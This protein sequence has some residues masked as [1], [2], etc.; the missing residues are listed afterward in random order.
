MLYLTRSTPAYQAFLQRLRTARRYAGLTQRDVARLLN[1]PQSFVSKSELGERRVDAVEA[2]EF[3][4]VYNLSLEEL[5]VGPLA[6]PTS[7]LN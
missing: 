6:K 5:L 7:E 3:A 2:V 4:R 1:K